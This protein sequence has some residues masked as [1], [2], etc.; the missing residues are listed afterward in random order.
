MSPMGKAN[1]TKLLDRSYNNRDAQLFVIA[2]EGA[3]TEKSGSIPFLQR[4]AGNQFPAS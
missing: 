4:P 3:K 2:T 1:R